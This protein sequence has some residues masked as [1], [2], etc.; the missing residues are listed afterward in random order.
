MSGFDARRILD[1]LPIAVWIGRVPDGAAV[2]ANAASD[3]VLGRVAAADADISAAPEVYGIVDLE[4]RP[5]PVEQLPFSRV[6]ATN[7]PALVEGLAI[8]RPDGRRV[9]V[10]AWASP[11]RDASGAMTHVA[12]AFLDI[13]R[14][15]EAESEREKVAERL[16]FAIAHAPI[17]FWTADR[18]GVVTLSEGAG[19]AGLGVRSG[20]LVGKSIFELYADHPQVLAH[21]RRSLAG[22]S[23]F[24]VSDV[25]P[26][27]YE[28]YLTPTRDPDGEINGVAGVSHEVTELR[29]LQVAAIDSDRIRAL[30]TLAASVA[31]EINN[32]LT[33][34]LSSLELARR[35]LHG[36]EQEAERGEVPPERLRAALTRVRALLEPVGNGTERIATITRDLRTFTRD[37]TTRGA[38]DVRAALDVVL[39]LVRK[40]LEAAAELVVETDADTPPVR[41]NE[42]RVVQVLLNLLTNAMHA[43]LEAPPDRKR[44]I[45]VRVAPRGDAV[46]IEIGDSGPG[47]PRDQVERIFEP[48]VTTKPIG[49][50]SGLGLF[51]SRNIVR[52]F[53]GELS[54]RDRPG[55]GALFRVE[56]APIRGDV[57]EAAPAIHRLTPSN[58]RQILVVED[59][60]VLLRIFKTLLERAGYEVLTA[61]DGAAALELLTSE[62]RIDLTFCDL[63]MAGTTG[64]DVAAALEERAPDRLRRLVF[65]TGGAFTPAGEQ[66]LRRTAIDVVHKPFDIVLEASRRL[67]ARDPQ[68]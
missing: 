39:G 48:F 20:E 40:E 34:V 44:R 64:M 15:R 25:G 56:L 13:T 52:G 58:A 50:G 42:G 38:V 49:E 28:T 22:E 14:E 3:E 46:V 26:V 45:E 60:P 68:R 36:L 57:V 21:V 27:T 6:L 8:Q 63:M 1:G 51:V 53:G 59:E 9:A 5:F 37:E 2:Y 32:P 54:V 41:A 12:I 35:A 47:V 30:G 11:V 61:V 67:G 7:A 19:L 31:H 66:F 43:V 62:R 24:Y 23:H 18:D 17:V 29:R 33:Y 55:G 65:M 16:A 10:R 4:G